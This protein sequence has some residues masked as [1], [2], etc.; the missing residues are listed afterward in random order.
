MGSY[1]CAVGLDILKLERTSMFYSA[2]YQIW[3]GGLELCFGGAKPIKAPPLWLRDCGAKLQLGFKC[4][5]LRKVL[6]LRD[7]SNLLFISTTGPKVAQCIHV[8]SILLHEAKPVLGLFC[9][10][11]DTTGWSGHVKGCS[12]KKRGVGTLFPH[13][14]K[15]MAISNSSN[16][17][18][19]CL[20][21]LLHWILFHRRFL[22][23]S[24][25]LRVTSTTVRSQ[26]CFNEIV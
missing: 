5:W 18:S 10:H 23:S 19:I 12:V 11:L 24:A 8:L 3:G 2:S 6:R 22:I 21:E 1:T 15:R 26:P 13:Q 9:L 7:M 4:N 20:K 16:E 17:V 14:I 25:N